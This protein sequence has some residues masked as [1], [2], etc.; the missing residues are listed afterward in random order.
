MIVFELI[1]CLKLNYI[2]HIFIISYSLY[3]ELKEGKE[4]GKSQGERALS[5][6]IQTTL[7]IIPNSSIFSITSSRPI[8]GVPLKANLYPT[9]P[10]CQRHESN[11]ILLSKHTE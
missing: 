10:P 3:Y 2:H 5:P 4:K 7:L 11:Q 1:V 8:S 9:C 6:L